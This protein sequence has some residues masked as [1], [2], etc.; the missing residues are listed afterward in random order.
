M[1]DKKEYV[2][3]VANISSWK[4]WKRTISHLGK[5]AAQP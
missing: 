2:S 4:K 1:N 5:K 3:I